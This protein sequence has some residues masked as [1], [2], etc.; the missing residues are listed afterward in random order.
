MG[1]DFPYSGKK[2]DQGEKLNWGER[3]G[4]RRRE[5]LK[6]SHLGEKREE[7]TSVWKESHRYWVD[8]IMDAALQD[9][10]CTGRRQ[11][12]EKPHLKPNDTHMKKKGLTP[13]GKIKTKHT[14]F[15]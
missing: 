6:G 15:H 14:H 2:R 8:V 1:D 5:S 9:A 3:M 13:A 12:R 7:R 11:E 10:T 4:R